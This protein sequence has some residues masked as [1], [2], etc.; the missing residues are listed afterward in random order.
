L[1][2][3]DDAA[4]HPTGHTAPTPMAPP[5]LAFEGFLAFD[6]AAA[7]G[8]DEPPCTRR[9]TPPA[10]PGEGETPQDGFVRIEQDDLTPARLV[11]EGRRVGRKSTGRA[12]EAHRIFFKAQR[13]LSRPSWRPVCLVR[14]IASSRQLHWEERAPC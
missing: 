12:I 7:Q 13:T 14:T 8:A 9:A 1:N 2:G 6:L 10:Q 11:R 4:Q 5:R 3:A